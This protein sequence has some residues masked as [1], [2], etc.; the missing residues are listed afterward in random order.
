MWRGDIA[1]AEERI[2]RGLAIARESGSVAA[3]ASCQVT[4]SHLRRAQDRLDESIEH[5]REALRLFLEIG[6][7]FSA[8]TASAL[9]VAEPLIDADEP[10]EAWEVLERGLAAGAAGTAAEGP[11]RI[12]RARVLLMRG[13]PDE[14]EAELDRVQPAKGFGEDDAVALRAEVRAAQGRT[15]EA[16][17]LWHEVLAGL[18]SEQRLD[19]AELGLPFAAFLSARGRHEEAEA[20][21]EEIRSL[22]AGSGAALVERR[23]REVE[24]LLAGRGA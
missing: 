9:A 7:L 3:I 18:P 6:D 14:A 11:I 20:A 22:V 23:V 24:A 19:R 13:T 16:E 4:L 10:D 12:R 15:D 17:R 8:W 5:G 2:G 21:L 1:L